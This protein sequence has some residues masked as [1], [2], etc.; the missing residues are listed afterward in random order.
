MTKGKISGARVTLDGW[1]FR[2]QSCEFADY[3]VDASLSELDGGNLQ[4]LCM[5]K[6]PVP[7]QPSIPLSGNPGKLIITHHADTLG[8]W[9]LRRIRQ[10]YP[11]WALGAV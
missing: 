7:A 1:G 5:F 8:R 6:C 9:T 10:Q 2:Y 3:C 11:A 4:T